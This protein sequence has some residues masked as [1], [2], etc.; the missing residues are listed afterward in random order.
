MVE[1]PEFQEFAAV[2]GARSSSSVEARVGFGD[3][4]VQPVADAQA[5]VLPPSLGETGFF[6]QFGGIAEE[7]LA[8]YGEHFR[9]GERG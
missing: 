5:A 3:G 9:V 1:P 4:V 2:E 6:A 7:D 8:G